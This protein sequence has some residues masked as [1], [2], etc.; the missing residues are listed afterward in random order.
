MSGELLITL[1]KEKEKPTMESEAQFLES[2]KLFWPIKDAILS[3]ERI[4]QKENS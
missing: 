1:L 2:W 3:L 4:K